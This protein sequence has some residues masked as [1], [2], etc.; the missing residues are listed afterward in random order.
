VRTQRITQPVL[1]KR[2]G[3]RQR[4]APVAQLLRVE[5]L[6]T[7]LDFLWKPTH[8]SQLQRHT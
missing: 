2:S 7:G 8:A 3:T 1:I 6:V 4:R 5:R